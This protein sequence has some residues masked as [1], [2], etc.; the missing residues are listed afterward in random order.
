MSGAGRS[1][2][3]ILVGR[4]G[5]AHGIRG[6]VRVNSF[7]DDPVA[8]A[9]YGPLLT[10]RE[11]LVL[12]VE[13]AR[14]QSDAGLIVRFEGIADRSAAEALRGLDLYITRDALPDPEDSEDF[15][16][17][18]LIG[19]EARL[20]G[21]NVLGRVSALPNYGA[22]DLIEITDPQSGD[23]FLYPFTKSIVPDIRV[24]EGYLV[25]DPPL[26][27]EPGEEEPD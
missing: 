24:G 4:I 6:E 21:G 14:P 10:G 5:T 9:S 7:T 1:A 11:N 22:G 15:Y 2:K 13:S 27:A 16:H 25:I 26:D 3:R 18:D 20:I 12:T 17:A 8:L 19:L 23:T